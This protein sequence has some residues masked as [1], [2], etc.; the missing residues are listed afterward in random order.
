MKDS[1]FLFFLCLWL[2]FLYLWM[3]RQVLGCAFAV[4]VVVGF[5]CEVA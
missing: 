2:L 3:E 4:V 5:G 1:G